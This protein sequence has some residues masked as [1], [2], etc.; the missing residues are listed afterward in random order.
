MCSWFWDIDWQK[1]ID[2]EEK[3]LESLKSSVSITDDN[4]VKSVDDTK[5]SFEKV[6]STNDK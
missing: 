4:V 5:K 1:F 6:V 2:E 3:F